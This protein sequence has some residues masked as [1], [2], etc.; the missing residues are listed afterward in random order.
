MQTIFWRKRRFWSA[1]RFENTMVKE[2]IMDIYLERQVEVIRRAAGGVAAA[3]AGERVLV[4][5]RYSE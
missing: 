2:E 1:V 3:R 5:W 4:S